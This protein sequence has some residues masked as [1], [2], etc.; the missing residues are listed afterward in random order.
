MS[1]NDPTS[2]ISII[3]SALLIISEILPFLPC[4]PNGLIDF[5]FKLSPCCNQCCTKSNESI[6]D[7]DKDKDNII[8]RLLY[9]ILDDIDD[10]EDHKISLRDMKTNIKNIIHHINGDSDPTV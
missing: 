5:I 8:E 10:L 4:K 7:K 6:K 9:S 1:F 2:Y 3:S